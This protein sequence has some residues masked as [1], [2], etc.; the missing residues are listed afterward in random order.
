MKDVRYAVLK[1]AI[2]TRWPGCRVVWEPYSS[3]DDPLIQGWVHI[4]HVRERDR[5]AVDES[6]YYL[7]R[8]LFPGPSRFF[9]AAVLREDQPATLRRL[10][11]PPRRGRSRTRLAK[12]SR[13]ARTPRRGELAQIR[14][15]S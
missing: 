7:V 2:E 11:L 10:G 15:R 1:K 8:G 14:A 12:R 5:H 13:V 9:I 3:P 6:A 4:L